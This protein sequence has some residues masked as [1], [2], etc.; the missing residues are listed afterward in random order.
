VST[1]RRHKN[2]RDA[3]K[4]PDSFHDKRSVSPNKIK[5]FASHS[6]FTPIIFHAAA[7]AAHLSGAAGTEQSRRF[8]DGGE[9]ITARR[10]FHIEVSASDNDY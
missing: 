8:A 6:F 10:A 4:N 7:Y 5:L 9:P 1:R 3:A 2:T